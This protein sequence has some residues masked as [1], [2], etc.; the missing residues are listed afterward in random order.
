MEPWSVQAMHG[1][2]LV[3]ILGGIAVGDSTSKKSDGNRLVGN[4]E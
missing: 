3:R 1:S 2:E 4:F